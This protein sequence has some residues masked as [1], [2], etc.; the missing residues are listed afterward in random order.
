[1]AG[2]GSTGL[3][4][5]AGV[6]ALAPAGPVGAANFA[7]VVGID[8]YA[9][10]PDLGGAVNDARLIASA[11]RR[12]GVS[13]M[14]VL[15]DGAA[16]RAALETAWNSL[17]DGAAS[18]DTII[19]T[20]SGHGAQW[21]DDSGDEA[22]AGQPDD[23]VDEMLVLP[24]F[25]AQSPAGRE[26]MILDDELN[27]WFT[28]ARDRQV[29]VVFVADSCYS[30]TVT[31]GGRARVLPELVALADSSRRRP[32][33]RVPEND[34]DTLEN[35]V[36]MAGAREAEVVIEV[37][38]EGRSHGALS[39]AFSRSLAMNGD[40]NGDG[41]LSRGELAVFIPR[42]AKSFNGARYLPELVARA[43]PDVQVLRPDP[44]AASAAAARPEEDAAS[45]AAADAIDFDRVQ[46]AAAPGTYWDRR[47]GNIIDPSGEVLGYGL[48]EDALG[49]VNDKFATLAL[50]REGLVRKGFDMGL[51]VDGQPWHRE[52]VG[53]QG[54]EIAV[55]PLP[56][57]YLTVFNLA[58]NGQVQAI[59]PIDAKESGPMPEG[60]IQRFAA[61]VQPPFGAD[62]IVAI[63][64]AT[65][66]SDLRDALRYLLP[67]SELLPILSRLLA[68]DSVAFAHQSLVTREK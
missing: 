38:I 56:F 26:E 36:F 20:Y 17:L 6:L 15:L 32:G 46:L 63:S 27:Q 53:G 50:A 2:V 51:V 45:P 35:L 11:L 57:P 33:P 44:A 68:G 25:D 30:G 19:F 5:L 67:S 21:P 14:D 55:G 18:G 39:Y 13:R 60:G 12:F 24:G 65:P 28:R 37:E 3:A 54:F 58:N 66:P 48:P 31:R 16:D 61:E 42:T 1:M 41:A 4:A 52:L 64:T 34:E 40:A 43:G 49:S 29:M 9:H 22:T 10:Q 47:T 8:D 7:L 23:R 62:E 59:F